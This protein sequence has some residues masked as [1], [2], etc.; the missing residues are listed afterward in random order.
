MTDR[1]RLLYVYVLCF[2]CFTIIS[3]ERSEHGI[4]SLVD[5]NA[6]NGRMYVLLEMPP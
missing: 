2:F 1:E 3:E 6:F 4:R 5:N